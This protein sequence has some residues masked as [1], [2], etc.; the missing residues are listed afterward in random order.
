MTRV[1]LGERPVACEACAGTGKY[2]GACDDCNGEGYV[3]LEIQQIGKKARMVVA[4]CRR[5]LAS[6][7]LRT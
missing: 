3:M 7:N 2:L 1:S 5:C 6:G 4:P